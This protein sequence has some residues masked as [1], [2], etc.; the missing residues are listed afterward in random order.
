MD[1]WGCLNNDVSRDGVTR[2]KKY[3]IVFSVRRVKIAEE[4][5]LG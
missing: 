4:N 2:S 1:K 3:A 5:Y